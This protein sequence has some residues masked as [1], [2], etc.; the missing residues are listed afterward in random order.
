MQNT[1]LPLP[2]AVG[3]VGGKRGRFVPEVEDRLRSIPQLPL[4]P[5]IEYVT[6]PE[7]GAGPSR[8]GSASVSEL[9]G[10]GIGA[11]RRR[12]EKEYPGER[13][14]LERV[15]I[16]VRDIED[17][18]QDVVLAEGLVEVKLRLN[19]RSQRSGP[20]SSSSSPSSPMIE[21]ASRASM[22][23][24]SIGRCASRFIS[25]NFSRVATRTCC[26]AITADCVSGRTDP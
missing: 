23:S 6:P 5:L 10:P 19:N 26:P 1:S 24:R 9:V 8:V 3:L 12:S 15:A 20:E 16:W 17:H 2:R 22:S 25:I 4:N 7:P 14:A 18:G 13:L 11:V 21:I